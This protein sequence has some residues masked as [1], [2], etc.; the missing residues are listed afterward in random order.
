MQISVQ[1]VCYHVFVDDLT[2]ILSPVPDHKRSSWVTLASSSSCHV[3]SGAHHVVE[4]SFR[5]RFLD[6]LSRRWRLNVWVVA[7]AEIEQC[8]PILWQYKASLLLASTRCVT[9]DHA[10]TACSINWRCTSTRWVIANHA[11]TACSI[12]SVLALDEFG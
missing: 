1:C 4:K 3:T 8:D 11:L 10:L 12:G 9:G 6:V 2:L 7:F 5:K